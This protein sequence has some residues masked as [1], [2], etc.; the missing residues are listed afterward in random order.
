MLDKLTNSE[1]NTM[2]SIQ[3]KLVSFLCIFITTKYTCQKKSYSATTM[4]LQS[5]VVTEPLSIPAFCRTAMKQ[6]F[7]AHLSIPLHKSI[8]KLKGHIQPPLT[9]KTVFV[10]LQRSSV[11]PIE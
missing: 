3:Q 5:S 1:R 8:V 11:V 2:I 10:N 6:G 7:S 9:K 4:V